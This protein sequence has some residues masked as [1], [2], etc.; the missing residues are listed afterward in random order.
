MLIEKCP[1]CGSN[2]N[3]TNRGFNNVDL[4]DK[5]GAPFYIR[6]SSANMNDIWIGIKAMEKP[7]DSGYQG[8][9]IDDNIYSVL[10]DDALWRDIKRAVKKVRKK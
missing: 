8:N 9:K 7:T 1:H 10:I 6:Q 4:T 5:Y 3:K 2:V